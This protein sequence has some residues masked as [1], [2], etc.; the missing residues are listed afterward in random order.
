[1][2]A[3]DKRDVESRV[4]SGTA[5]NLFYDDRSG[6]LIAAMGL[7]GVVVV[8]PD[9]TSTRVA[10][11]RYSPTDFSFRS[12]V[13]TFFGS[14]L[15]GETAV[16]TG[17]ALLLAFSS[18]ALALVGPA[19]SAGPKS[20]F[21]LAAAISALLALSVGV[22]PHASGAPWVSGSQNLG[23]VVLL[24]S[25]FGLFPLSL[26]IGGLVVAR[27]GL[28]QVL[29]VV[30]AGI[31]MLLVILLGGLV[32]FEEGAR[33]ANFVAVGL[34]GLATLGLWAYQKRRQT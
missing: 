6:N 16:S 19:S 23:S 12:K 20:W 3:L 2:Q 24:L 8:A 21:A 7:Q 14:L 4:V 29:G 28:M 31:G 32:L 25:G 15:H 1:M 26:V 22:Y 13:G 34:V 9:G 11:G 17:V 33:T 5:Y 10:V 30:A 18:A 27:I